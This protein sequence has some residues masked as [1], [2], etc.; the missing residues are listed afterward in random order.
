M[1]TLF[2]TDERRI[3]LY[4]AENAGWLKIIS[5]QKDELPELE[6]MLPGGRVIETNDSAEKKLFKKELI[7][8]QEAMTQLNQAL[9]V[10]QQRLEKDTATRHLYDI[11]TLCSQDIL[12]EK[13][14]EIEKKYI[15]LKCSFMKFLAANI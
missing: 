15:E 14:R 1:S 11:D 4:L 7:Q 10:Q 12:R 5:A 13:I 6:K 9:D 3:Q 2:Q 8:Q